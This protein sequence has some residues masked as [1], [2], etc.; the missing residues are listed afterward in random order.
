MV[1]MLN[2]IHSTPSE[3]S[4]I[5][6]AS[7]NSTCNFFLRITPVPTLVEAVRPTLISCQDTAAALAALIPANQFWRWKDMWSNSL[8][9]AIFSAALIEYLTSGTLISLPQVGETLGSEPSHCY[10]ES[11][12]KIIFVISKG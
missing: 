11:A 6:L 12:I 1:G 9:T 10:P 5:K 2:K 4:Q 8:R 3:S 7:N